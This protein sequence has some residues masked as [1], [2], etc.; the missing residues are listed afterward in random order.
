MIK[1]VILSAGLGSRMK[2]D[3]PK[4]YL[5][6][7]GKPIIAYTIEAFENS[8]VDSIIL[9]CA[10][11]YFDLIN[12]IVEKYHYKKVE[13]VVEGGKERYNS[14]FNA[15]DKVDDMDKVLIHDGARPLVKA[16]YINN[17][18]ERLK[19]HKACILG[20]P[21]KDTIK[22]VSL[23]SLSGNKEKEEYIIDNTPDRKYLYIAQTPQGFDGALLKES[24]NRMI[25]D[26][27]AGKD[28]NITDDAMVV[29][30]YSSEKVMVLESDYTN[31]KVTT[32]DDLEYVDKVVE[33]NV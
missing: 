15:L 3:I 33:K 12:Y 27:N 31:I 28:V 20:M 25:L 7:K 29:E 16:E 4:Q 24:Y 1:A 6:I 13:C 10:R 5:E 19:V 8:N 11:E 21:V 18:I 26:I 22:V 2:S 14:V 30:G 32:R 23:V 9:V 17:M